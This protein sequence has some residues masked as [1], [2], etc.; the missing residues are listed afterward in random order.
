MSSILRNS[1][2]MG[3]FNLFGRASG[4]I[5]YWLLV[6]F[7]SKADFAL[8][9]YSFYV[10]RL[11][12]HFMDGGLDNLISRDGAR[13]HGKIA[14]YLFHGLL[15]KA[16]LGGLFG[17]GVF[18]YLAFTREKSWSELGVIYISLAGSAMLS[19]TGVLRSGFTA[20]ERMEYVFYTNLP[21]RMISIF[22][23]F[24]TVYFSL[25]LAAAAG[26]VSLENF[27]WFYLLA[28]AG[29]RFFSFLTPVSFSTI[30]YMLAESWSLALYG[31][32]NVFYLSLDVMMIEYLMG[33]D[34]AV[35]P[36]TYASLLIEGVTMMVSGYLIAIYPALSRYYQADEAA[37]RALFRQSVIVL[38]S[39]TVPISV[40]LAGWSYGWMNFIRETGLVSSQVLAVL[41]A[42]LNLS[43][44][45]TLIIV[46]FTS[47][48]RQRWLVAFTGGAVLISFLTNWVMIVWYGQVGAAAASFLS[49]L[50][51]LIAMGWI[52]WR[53]FA[54]PIPAGKAGGILLV[55]L[56]AGGITRLIPGLH[57]L[58]VPFVYGIFLLGLARLLGVMTPEE[59]SNILNTVRRRGIAK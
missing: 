49:Q 1:I 54:L 19:L 42:T 21:A 27:I 53:L 46:V 28:S 33:G 29:L 10:G 5:R 52:A 45:N 14:D 16:I 25:P 4:L 9:T 6:A 48:H 31:F 37:Y 51:L 34:E 30:K 17:V 26:A 3:L 8:I 32:F 7:L 44:L 58:A 2:F 47:R 15:L 35:A 41:A 43:V 55:S 50:I 11:G 40:L 20:A 13:T 23:L 24:L 22:L 12:R 36:Y 56:L 18:F 39:I 59:M 57:L 38:L